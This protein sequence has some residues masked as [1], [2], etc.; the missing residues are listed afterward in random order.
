MRTLSTFLSNKRKATIFCLTILV[1][2]GSYLRLY[3]LSAQSFWL[4]ESVT[5]IATEAI[6]EQGSPLLYSGK[7]YYCLTYCYPTALITSI[8]GESEF[9]YRI[10]SVVFGILFILLIFFSVRKLFDK[11]TALLSAL[12]VT[13]SYWQIAWSRQARW[14]TMFE[15][16]FFLAI[17]FFYKGYKGTRYRK[18]AIVL[19]IVFTILSILTHG[20]GYLLPFIFITWIA[21]DELFISKTRNKKILIWIGSLFIISIFILASLGFADYQIPLNVLDLHYLLPYYLSFYIRTYWLFI[22]FMIFA[23]FVKKQSVTFKYLFFIL[24]AYLLSLSL[25]TSTLQYRYL[26]HITPIIYILGIVGMVSIFDLIKNNRLKVVYVSV[27]VL[28]FFIFGGGSIIPKS[29]Y[30]L[31]RDLPQR[32]SNRPFYATTPQPDW[33]AAYEYVA[34]KKIESDV[35]ISTSPTFNKIYFNE[36]GFWLEFQYLGKDDSYEYTKNGQERYVGAIV[37][38]DISMLEEISKKRGYVIFDRQG[39]YN[40][41]TPELYLYIQEHFTEVFHFKTN[42]SSEIWV[43]K[44]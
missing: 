10:L 32:L 13:F 41:R 18:T 33:K 25:L 22:P 29:T 1:I 7:Y 37:V 16:F 3:S 39:L 21:L 36:P 31:E 40:N 42:E 24:L 17:T 26:F 27:F 44:F 8:F 20:L 30:F 5:V 43:Y 23:L 6:N 4:D 34:K 38:N 11:K 35:I 9:N 15:F 2:I 19:S 14:Y 28:L 12:V